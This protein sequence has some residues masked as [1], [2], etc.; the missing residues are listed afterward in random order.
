MAMQPKPVDHLNLYGPLL[1]GR[2][3]VG[4]PGQVLR[5]M[6]RYA[7][8]LWT[9]EGETIEG[10]GPGSGT[11]HGAMVVPLFLYADE[12]P[13]DGPL[14]FVPPTGP[15]DMSSFMV[16]IQ[17]FSTSTRRDDQ[18]AIDLLL[19]VDLTGGLPAAVTV[20][21]DCGD[22]AAWCVQRPDG[23]LCVMVG[24]AKTHWDSPMLSITHLWV[25][26][27]PDVNRWANGWSAMQPD[28]LSGWQ[29]W[30]AQPIGFQQSLGAVEIDGR[31]GGRYTSC[32][33][34]FSAPGFLSG[35]IVFAAGEE[36]PEQAVLHLVG[37]GVVGGEPTVNCWLRINGVQLEVVNLAPTMP[38]RL[39]AGIDE[40]GRF[41]I[42][43]GEIDAGWRMPALALAEAVSARGLGSTFRPAW[44][45]RLVTSLAGFDV[46]IEGNVRPP[47][48]TGG[49]GG[50]PIDLQPL[51]PGTG[52]SGAPFDGTTAQTWTVDFSA[53]PPPTVSALTPGAHLS[54]GEFNGSTPRTW[55]VV[56]SSDA[57]PGQ[58]MVR[59]GSGEVS[60][61]LFR[62]DL[63]GT[64][65]NATR[66]VSAGTA[67]LATL[68][69]AANRL[70]PGARINGV[71]FDG[72]S[73]IVVGDISGGPSIAT[74]T[75]GAGIAGAP[76]DGTT[77]QTWTV[78]AAALPVPTLEALT[79]GGGL[80]GQ[81]F[82]GRNARTWAVDFSAAPPLPQAHIR[83]HTSPSRV[84]VFTWNSAISARCFGHHLGA[85]GK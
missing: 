10:P 15:G 81:P 67:D 8:P 35:A 24:T 72:S 77:A 1:D 76:F 57:I 4:G 31:G 65:T 47:A 34:G 23:R 43:V 68:A 41:C 80:I 59:D 30:G 17:G 44:T 38:P 70:Q 61:R 29:A 75:P 64:A 48:G 26:G 11:D 2:E 73:D 63:Q 18:G 60:A 14:V 51:T 54:G 49:G 85:H 71:L 79:P 37:S 39:R 21:G 50:G 42:I 74:L 84:P 19:Q 27:S 7:A 78:D 82:D 36:V 69:N 28:D 3:S 62:G 20:Q 33:G 16:H 83:L 12:G 32:L 13:S 25:A 56:A 45:S 6:G 53:M 55:A 66:A 5:S 52:L 22:M 9:D 46:G 40:Q 58:L